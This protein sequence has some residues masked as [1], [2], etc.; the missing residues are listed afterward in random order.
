MH[1][2]NAMISKEKFNFVKAAAEA[3]HAILKDLK[4]I[5]K[6]EN[7][8]RHDDRR[9]DRPRFDRGGVPTCFECDRKGHKSFECKADEAT[10]AAHKLGGEGEATRMRRRGAGLGDGGRRTERVQGLGPH[11]KR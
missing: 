11:W 1:V 7:E 4:D 6:Q 8:R 10:R 2:K 9:F 3:Q 5:G